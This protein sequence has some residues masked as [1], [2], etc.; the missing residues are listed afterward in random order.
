MLIVRNLWFVSH[1]GDGG[2]MIIGNLA[3]VEGVRRAQKPLGMSRSSA[4]RSSSQTCWSLVADAVI[5]APSLKV[6]KLRKLPQEKVLLE[7]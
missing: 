1:F 7:L 2:H 6:K 5:E 3:P 4:S